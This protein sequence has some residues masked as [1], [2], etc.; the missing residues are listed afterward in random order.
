MPASQGSAPLLG[1]ARSCVG[2]LAP[3]QGFLSALVHPWAQQDAANSARCRAYIVPRL[4]FA[5]LGVAALPIYLACA[6]GSSAADAVLLAAL[7]VPLSLTYYV[8][9]TGQIDRASLIAA[10]A[11]SAVALALGAVTG[12]VSSVSAAWFVLVPLEAALSRSRRITA[13]AVAV[14]MAGMLVLALMQSAALLPAAALEGPAL[15][16]AALVPLIYAGALMLG[17]QWSLQSQA[18]HLGEDVERMRLLAAH[19]HDVIVRHARTGAALFV[20]PSAQAVFSVSPLELLGHR[21]FDRVHVADRPAYLTAIADA[22]AQGTERAVEFRIRCGDAGVSTNFMWAEMRCRRIGGVS[23]SELQEGTVLSIIR[24]ISERKAQEATVCEARREAERANAAKSRFLAAMSHELRTPLNAIIGFSDM[25]TKAD[26][27]AIDAERRAEYA[28]LIHDSGHHLLSVVNEI[29]DLSKLEAG[30]FVIAPE[31]FA[32]ASVVRASC[33]LLALKAHEAGLEIVLQ[34]PELPDIV[35]DKRALKQILL[36][37]LS[38]A[39]KFSRRGGRIT[40]GATVGPSGI[41]ISVQDT[42]V[43]IPLEDLPRIG[44]PF[45]QVGTPYDRSSD[46]SGLGLSIVKGLV[47]LHH[48]HMEIESRVEQGTRVT[49]RLPLDCEDKD[50]DKDGAQ[51]NVSLISAHM[52]AAPVQAQ[53]QERGVESPPQRQQIERKVR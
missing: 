49:V 41:G 40:V 34:L 3:F 51:A 36:N 25:L 48:G 28:K 47:E 18:R 45:F 39:I 46:G 27:L 8:S 12:G 31:S 50:R 20:S 52:R 29:L 21:L 23:E 2:H 24:D 37:L 33:D 6:A 4:G 44:D 7:I 13:A 30:R 16:F 17:L 43:G 32:P 1:G 14:A 53:A 11:M 5:L 26:M 10:G 15:Q 22:A 42:G 19:A 38:N 35:A 9:R